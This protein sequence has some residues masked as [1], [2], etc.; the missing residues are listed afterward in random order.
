MGAVEKTEAQIAALPE[1]DLRSFRN[2][3]AE[4]DAER[5][6]SKIAADAAAGK[7]DGLAEEALKQF[8]NGQC[9]RL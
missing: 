3:F 4:F 7:L 2:W 1:S 5:W 9:K 6:D 8:G